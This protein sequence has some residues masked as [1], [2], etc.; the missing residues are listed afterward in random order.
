MQYLD[1]KFKTRIGFY[2]KDEAAEHIGMDIPTFEK[3]AHRL[4]IPPCRIYG[5]PG[6]WFLGFDLMKMKHRLA[7]EKDPD[8]CKI[9]EDAETVDGQKCRILTEYGS[10]LDFHPWLWIN[11]K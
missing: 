3:E 4:D 10:E 7:H 9:R 8:N 1:R 2:S 11:E 5:K 6:Q